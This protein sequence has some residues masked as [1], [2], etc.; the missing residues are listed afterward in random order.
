[1]SYEM[2]RLYFWYSLLWNDC[3][4]N[5]KKEIITRSIREFISDIKQEVSKKYAF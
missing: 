4:S 1:M 3:D 2:A 5:L